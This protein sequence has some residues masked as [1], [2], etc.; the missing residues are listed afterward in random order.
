MILT[1]KLALQQKSY[2]EK[3]LN[4][5]VITKSNSEEIYQIDKSIM[6]IVNGTF[7]KL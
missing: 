3:F 2:W 1:E 4:K 6:E 5:G 7:N